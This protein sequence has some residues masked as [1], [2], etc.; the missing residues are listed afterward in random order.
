MQEREQLKERGLEQVRIQRQVWGG[1]EKVNGHFLGGNKRKKD[2]M[3]KNGGG[4]Q[5]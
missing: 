3:R 5:I 2:K 4:L 1:L